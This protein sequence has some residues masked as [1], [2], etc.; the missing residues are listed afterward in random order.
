MT[1]SFMSIF[2]VDINSDGYVDIEDDGD[3][4][5]FDIGAL[6]ANYEHVI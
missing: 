2:S 6:L 1:L 5:L 3:V 4:D